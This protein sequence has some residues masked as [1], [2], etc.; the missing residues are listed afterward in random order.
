MKPC[1]KCGKMTPKASF[2]CIHC[3]APTGTTGVVIQQNAGRIWGFSMLGG[4]FFGIMMSAISRILG[5]GTGVGAVSA[6]VLLGL[7]FGVLFGVLFA[8]VMLGTVK[9]LERQWAPKRAEVAARTTVIAEGA[10]NLN[11]SGG[12]LFVTTDGIEYYTHRVN[13][14]QYN[15]QIAKSDIQL[16][17]AEGQKLVV[18]GNGVRYDFVV[19]YIDRWLMYIKTNER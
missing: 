10:A 4:L 16:V 6:L 2:A 12:W 7:P 13:F 18:M 19:N 1:T 11:G 8:L 5:M 17:F 14:N 15:M 9:K 3:G